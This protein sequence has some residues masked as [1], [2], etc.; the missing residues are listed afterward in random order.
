MKSGLWA[1]T[2][3]PNYFGESVMWWGVG[4]LAITHNF[5]IFAL[6]SPILITY[7]LVFVSGV[8]LLEK[9]YSNNLEFQE[10]AEYTSKFIPLP[11]KRR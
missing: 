6:V 4:F 8:P 7:L 5:G 3:H 9:K 2:R 11:R 1:Y 10:Y